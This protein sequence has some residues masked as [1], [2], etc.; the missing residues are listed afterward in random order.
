MIFI[1]TAAVSG[2]ARALVV[3][4]ALGTELG[5]IAAMI[6]KVAEAEHAETPLKRRLEHF[7]Y[8]LL[9]LALGVVTVVFL[10][11]YLRGE[12]AVLMLL[13]AASLAVAAVPEGLPA[14]VTITLA[15]GG[16]SH[17]DAPCADPQAARGRNARVRHGHLLR[18]DRYS[19]QERNDGDEVVRRRPSVRG[20]G[21]RV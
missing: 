1:G 6:Q 9:W 13:T 18:Q 5:R 2:K 8:T 7:G 10:L 12:P 4:T 21:R 16:H 20:H 15:L 19:D 14:V 11:S 17:G 3:A